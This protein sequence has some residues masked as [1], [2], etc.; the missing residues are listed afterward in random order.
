[1][2]QA[3][4]QRCGA[5]FFRV[6]HCGLPATEGLGAFLYL[7][8]KRG[9]PRI[10]ERGFAHNVASLF[11]SWAGCPPALAILSKVTVAMLAPLSVG[12]IWV[13]S[14]RH[15][16][17]LVFPREAFSGLAADHTGRRNLGLKL[18]FFYKALKPGGLQRPLP[19]SE[20]PIVVAAFFTN[21]AKL[22]RKKHLLPP[23]RSPWEGEA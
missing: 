10:F 21:Q 12:C 3:P 13:S 11:L 19:L 1:M 6:C 5:G 7:F 18:H 23:N 2:A 14:L 22:S 9:G 16:H 4:S 17:E 15:L 20:R 8:A